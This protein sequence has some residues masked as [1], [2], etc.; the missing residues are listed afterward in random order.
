M[1]SRGSF[2]TG[3]FYFISSDGR[4]V[5]ASASGAV[6]SGFIPFRVKPM[7]LKLVTGMVYLLR[8][9]ERHL[10]GSPHLD[11]IGRWPTTPK[12]AILRLLSRLL[13]LLSRDKKINVQLNTIQNTLLLREQWQES[14][15]LKYIITVYHR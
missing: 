13:R 1:R 12:R 5:K 14:K 15:V 4:V 2:H 11:M 9:W 6:E 3:S 8:R 10:A 7:T